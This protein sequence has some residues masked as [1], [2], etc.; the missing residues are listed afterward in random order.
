MLG[1]RNAITARQTPHHKLANC[2]H[3][4]TSILLKIQSECTFV[5]NSSNKQTHVKGLFLTTEKL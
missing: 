2:A 4:S 1:C 5:R 3:N